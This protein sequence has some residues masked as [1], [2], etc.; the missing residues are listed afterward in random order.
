MPTFVKTIKAGIA[1]GLS[2]ALFCGAALSHE[3]GEPLRL[4]KYRVFEAN[5]DGSKGREIA[6]SIRAIA[7]FL[8][9]SDVNVERGLIEGEIG[10]RDA[11]LSGFRDAYIGMTPEGDGEKT[12]DILIEGLKENGAVRAA[13]LEMFF[14]A[15]E[16]KKKCLAMGP[17]WDI[18][19]KP[20]LAVSTL[21]AGYKARPVSEP[22]EQG[23]GN[24]MIDTVKSILCH[25]ST[26]LDSKIINVH[27]AWV[28]SVIGN[29]L[30]YDY[31]VPT[32]Y[33]MMFGAGR[34]GE[35]RKISVTTVAIDGNRI[36]D[37]DPIYASNP[38]AC[39]EII[40]GKFVPTEG[41][42]DETSYGYQPVFCAGGN[43]RDN[44]PYLD[45]TN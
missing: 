32:P 35:G 30:F 13:V 18:A 11:F 3:T 28:F 29:G 36:P 9:G 8:N 40:F 25:N 5:D 15:Q 24:F 1:A 23:T 16:G 43:C 34:G 42:L 27:V 41:V 38:D 7:H 10:V 26:T 2:L 6:V 12:A 21:E 45:A 20:V 37:G 33:V 44:P 22:G 19:A 14:V 31:S 4:V 39:I 17:N